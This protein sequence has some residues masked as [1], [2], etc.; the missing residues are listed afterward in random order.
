[1]GSGWVQRVAEGSAHG[2]SCRQGPCAK[3]GG[4]L[5]QG[6]ASLG[7]LALISTEIN[8]CPVCFLLPQ[9]IFNCI[10]SSS[11]RRPNSSELISEKDLA[12]SANGSSAAE[13]LEEGNL[14]IAAIEDYKSQKQKHRDNKSD[15]KTAA[16]RKTQTPLTVHDE[17]GELEVTKS[18][19]SRNKLSSLKVPEAAPSSSANS[20][21][22]TRRSVPAPAPAPAPAPL[23]TIE[24]SAES[25]PPSQRQTRSQASRTSEGPGQDQRT[26]EKRTQVDSDT[27]VRLSPPATTTR[28]SRRQITCPT[29]SARPETVR[30]SNRAT[31]ADLQQRCPIPSPSHSQSPA[32]SQSQSPF[33]RSGANPKSSTAAVPL[34]QETCSPSNTHATRSRTPRSITEA[35]A[36]ASAASL[37]PDVTLSFSAR[38][39]STLRSATP[40]ARRPST[41][42]PN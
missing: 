26:A 35:K 22:R 16:S 6:T 23:S 17:D 21:A 11:W 27:T 12:L 28:S 40:A 41:G 32:M 18:T 39:T 34:S 31:S 1:M 13:Q 36:I 38:S 37:D 42:R 20:V 9:F 25:P 10:E 4:G 24:S 30:Q 19:A 29:A 15:G 8:I 7:A 14:T 3:E 5:Q 33:L 2:R